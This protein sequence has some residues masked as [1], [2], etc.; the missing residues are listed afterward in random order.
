MTLL[1]RTCLVIAVWTRCVVSIP[2]NEPG[3]TPVIDA[4]AAVQGWS[5]APTKAPHADELARRQAA[6][7]SLC[8]YTSG[9]FRMST[10]SLS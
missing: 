4:D 9:A 8:G 5:L 7:N 3:A 1:L 2:W 10:L 6:P